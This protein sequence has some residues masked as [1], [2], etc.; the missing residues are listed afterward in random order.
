MSDFLYYAMNF[1]PYFVAV[2]QCIMYIFVI[3]FLAKATKPIVNALKTYIANSK[4]DDSCNCN[5]DCSPAVPAVD[6]KPVDEN[7]AAE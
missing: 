5:C 6:E 2:V 3:I 1:F 7:K 4:K